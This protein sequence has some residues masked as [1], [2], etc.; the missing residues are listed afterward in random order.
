MNS[1]KKESHEIKSWAEVRETSIEIA[2]AIFEIANYDETLAE[3]IW[4]QGSDEVLVRAFAKTNK[5]QLY[6]GE[7]TIERKDV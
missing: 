3:K 2:E 7:D 5:S 1:H 6:W 4:E